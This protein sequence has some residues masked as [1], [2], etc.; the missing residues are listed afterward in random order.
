MTDEISDLWLPVRQII[1]NISNKHPKDKLEI[2][3]LGNEV[4]VLALKTKDKKTNFIRSF[5]KMFKFKIID[6]YRHKNRLKNTMNS[7]FMN[8]Y[9]SF[10]EDDSK[11]MEINENLDQIKQQLSDE[12]YELIYMKYGL[13]YEFKELSQKYQM[14][15]DALEIR[16]RRI[17]KRL[18]GLVTVE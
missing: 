12:D 15:E 14:S 13:E 6:Y 9:K 7:I 4:F 1:R 5:C 10:H 17:K 11:K 3:S 18:V 8:D 16:C 2:E